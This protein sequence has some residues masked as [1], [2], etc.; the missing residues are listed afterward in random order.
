MCNIK[1]KNN[2]NNNIIEISADYIYFVIVGEKNSLLNLIDDIEKNN[3][4]KN[5]KNKN[6]K[7][8][9]NIK[10]IVTRLDI[11]IL[12]RYNKIQ[13]M[14]TTNLKLDNSIESAQSYA[15]AQEQFLIPKQKTKFIENDTNKNYMMMMIEYDILRFPKIELTD[16]DPEKMILD[17]IKNNIGNIPV[18]IKKTIKP[19]SLVGY[20][21]EILVYMAKL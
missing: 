2:K 18:K 4:N 5:N 17:W 19:L 16:E 7:N 14:I 15:F 13:K 1:E 3:K 20:N 9:N 12:F 11:P 6:N 8:K 21:N 10:F